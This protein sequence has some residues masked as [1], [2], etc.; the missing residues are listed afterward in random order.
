M[1][2]WDKIK[3]EG[4]KPKDGEYLKILSIDGGGIRGLFPAQ[5]LAN[6]EK[7]TGKK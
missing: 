3:S 5:Y 7:S 1:L 6:I 2:D 4:W